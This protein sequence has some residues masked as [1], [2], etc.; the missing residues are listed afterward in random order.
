MDGSPP[1]RAYST[2]CVVA[3]S[4]LFFSALHIPPFGVDGMLGVGG[5][6]RVGVLDCVCRAVW[7]A[8]DVLCCSVWCPAFANDPLVPPMIV[9]VGSG[10][11]DRTVPWCLPHNFMKRKVRPAMV[12]H[13]T[14]SASLHVYP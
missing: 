6:Q 5:W 12:R 9:G 8:P 4:A 7:V 14:L 2:Q 3:R 1:S 11:G 10:L 13:G